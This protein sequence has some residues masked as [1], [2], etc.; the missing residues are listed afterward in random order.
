LP[1]TAIREQIASAIN[2]VVQ[3]SRLVDGSRKIIKISEVTGREGDV[4]MM[5]DIFVFNQTSF[6][7]DG[8]VVG[9]FEAT[10]NV[11]RFVD[12]LRQK[13]DLRIN[14]DL[15]KMGRPRTGP[16]EGALA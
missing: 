3:Q 8:R 1:S 7:D 9:A 11:P 10:G 16:G 13:G 4:I 2:L 5:Q 12:E 15:F 14:M 6:T